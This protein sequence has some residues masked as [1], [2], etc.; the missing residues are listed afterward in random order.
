MKMLTKRDNPLCLVSSDLLQKIASKPE[1]GD[2][3]NLIAG[4]VYV[5]KI[6]LFSRINVSAFVIL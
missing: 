1:E 5:F 3:N 2:K 6:I 4:K